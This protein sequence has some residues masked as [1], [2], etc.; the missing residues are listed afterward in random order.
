MRPPVLHLRDLGVGIVRMLPVLV[1]ALLLPLP[2][3]PRQVRAR[4]R[5]DARGLAPASSG[6]PRSSRPCRAARCC[7]APRS[8]PAS[9][10]RCRSSCPSPSRPSARRCRTHV[11]TARCVSRS[12]SRRVREIVEWSGGASSNANAEKVAQRQRVRR[13]PR[14]AALGVDALEV[15]DQQQPEVDARRQTRAGPSSRR[16]RLA[17]RFDE[18]VEA[19]LRAASDSAARRTGDSPPSADRSSRSTSSVVDCVSVCPSPWAECSTRPI[20]VL[21]SLRLV[22]D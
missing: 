8:P 5:L 2:I 19:L 10:R 12:I 22:N 1:R 14:D 11:K 16:R 9:S 20:A 21:G 7:A 3:E 18:V 13:A 17:Q 6:T 4:R 15:A